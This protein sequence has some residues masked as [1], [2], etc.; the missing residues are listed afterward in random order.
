MHAEQLPGGLREVDM[1]SSFET[2][3]DIALV[4]AWLGSL[5]SH[6]GPRIPLDPLSLSGLKTI[7]EKKRTS[8][9]DDQEI[10]GYQAHESGV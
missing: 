9:S 1:L 7:Q 6:V 8:R 2:I 5:V 4:T 10:I 3:S